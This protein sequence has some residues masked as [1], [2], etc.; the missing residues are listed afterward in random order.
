[1]K[2]GRRKFWPNHGSDAIGADA[3]SATYHSYWISVSHNFLSRWPWPLPIQW[4]KHFF[5]FEIFL[6]F[7][8][9]AY[10]TIIILGFVLVNDPRNVISL[11]LIWIELDRICFSLNDLGILCLR[12]RN[13]IWRTGVSFVVFVITLRFWWSNGVFFTVLSSLT[14]KR[15]R[16]SG[17]MLLRFGF[18]SVEIN[19]V[20]Q[21]LKML[22]DNR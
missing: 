21:M 1:V 7:G 15:A 2:N 18:D 16:S 5:C 19:S 9:I 12:L 13:W 20:M 22:V 4:C 8:S 6:L 17:R 10:L 11:I 3:I 14:R